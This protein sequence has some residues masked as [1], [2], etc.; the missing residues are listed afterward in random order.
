MA[1]KRLGVVGSLV[2]DVI[3]GRDVREA[4]I[5][6]WGGIAYALAG[7]EASLPDDWQIVP[8]IKVGRDLSR[9]AE[10]LFRSYR[11]MIPGGRCAE[12]TVP[13]NRVTLRYAE[14]ERRT[15]RMSGGVPGWSW[16][17]LGAL[18]RDLDAVYVNFI[19][20]FEMPLGTAQ[21][22]RQGFH[23]PIYADLHSLFFGM[24]PDGVRV[25]RPVEHVH[26]W[27]ACFDAVQLNEDEMRQ[28]STDPLGAAAEA[29][30]QGVSLVAVTLG[31]R[32]AVYVQASGSGPFAGG[33]PGDPVRTALIEAPRV[34]TIDP[35][36]CGDIFGAALVSRLLAGDPVD[37]AM[38]HANRLAARNASLRGASGLAPLLQGALVSA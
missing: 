26:Q 12:V 38:G 16:A 18:V 8:L 19:S 35:T 22:L 13:N 37:A 24:P 3:Y 32:G 4:P 33:S 11:R 17:E 9:E 29:L 23:G 5:E 25:L 20:G 36:G 15:E 1:V 28:I 10:Q 7:L 31:S 14:G 34:G 21:A 27:F 6:E 30:G 2:W